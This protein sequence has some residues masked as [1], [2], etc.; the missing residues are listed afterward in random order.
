MLYNT[1]TYLNDTCTNFPRTDKSYMFSKPAAYAEVSKG[2]GGGGITAIY[3]HK[4]CTY[5]HTKIHIHTH[6]CIYSHTHITS[7]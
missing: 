7:A 5:M 1:Y 3:I 4:K 6:I 2:G